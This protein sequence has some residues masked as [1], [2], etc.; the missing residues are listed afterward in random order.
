MRYVELLPRLVREL[1]LCPRTYYKMVDILSCQTSLTLRIAADKKCIT[2]YCTLTKLH[3]LPKQCAYVYSRIL[4]INRDHIPWHY[5]PTVL[6]NGKAES[7]PRSC[8]CIL[9]YY[10]DQGC[11]PGTGSP[12]RLNF[13][14]WSLI[15]AKPQYGTEFMSPLRRLDFDK[16]VYPWFRQKQGFGGD[17][18]RLINLLSWRLLNEGKNVNDETSTERKKRISVSVFTVE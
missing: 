16:F 1:Y 9:K 7:F 6:Y 15:F 11:K 17:K 14:R 3:S 2:W 12:G 10:L 8:N 18:Y 4:T 5:S 13:E